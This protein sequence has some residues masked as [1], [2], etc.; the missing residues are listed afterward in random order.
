MTT[1]GYSSWVILIPVYS[2]MKGSSSMIFYPRS[3]CISSEVDDNF[4]VDLKRV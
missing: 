1:F 4:A 3:G 2:I